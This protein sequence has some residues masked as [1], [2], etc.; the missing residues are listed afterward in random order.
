MSNKSL[1]TPESGWE[2]GFEV[3]KT[4]PKRGFAALVGLVN[5]VFPPLA[6]LL[7]RFS[8]SRVRVCDSPVLWKTLIN[9]YL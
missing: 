6:A 8:C 7:R 2:T 5:I 9:S 4:Y 3:L 1:F